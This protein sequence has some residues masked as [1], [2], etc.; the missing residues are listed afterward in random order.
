[1]EPRKLEDGN[2]TKTKKIPNRQ[3]GWCGMAWAR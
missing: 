1:M 3:C 2:K